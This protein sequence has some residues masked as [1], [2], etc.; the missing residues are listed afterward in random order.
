MHWQQHLPGCF[1]DRDGQFALHAADRKRA[2]QLLACCDT[3]NVPLSAVLDEAE[4]HLGG[5]H[6]ETV[7]DSA[8]FETHIAAQRQRIADLFGGWLE[9]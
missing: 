2:L 8:V 1:G 6:S 5:K 3:E 4:R 9:D 7:T